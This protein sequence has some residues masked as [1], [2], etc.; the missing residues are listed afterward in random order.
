MRAPNDMEIPMAKRH[1][2]FGSTK[3]LQEYEPLSF[4]LEGEEYYCRPALAGATLL[5]FVKEADSGDGGRSADAL[6]GLFEKILYPDDFDRFQKLW[7]DPDRI[8]DITTLG[9]IASWVVGEYT[10]RPTQAS[11]NSSDGRE[12]TG[13]GSTA[14]SSVGE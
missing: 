8:V 7:D 2:D 4:T 1:R 12:I 10:N 5:K 9:E 11:S 6:L 14:N 13:P 3:S